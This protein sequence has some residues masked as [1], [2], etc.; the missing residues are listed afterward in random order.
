[1]SSQELL[2]DRS[3]YVDECCVQIMAQ[4]GV[5]H[6]IVM[7]ENREWNFI[8]NWIVIKLKLPLIPR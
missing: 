5:E 1:M 3:A 8:S 2:K 7:N 6:V 4:R